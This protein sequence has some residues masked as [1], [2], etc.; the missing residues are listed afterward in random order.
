M[1]L[2]WFHSLCIST[3]L[4]HLRDLLHVHNKNESQMFLGG[5][6]V[7]FG[8][9]LPL[10]PGLKATYDLV[11]ENFLLDFLQ[12]LT[13]FRMLRAWWRWWNFS[14]ELTDN[15]S[16]TSVLSD[17]G[18]MPVSHHKTTGPSRSCQCP[19]IPEPHGLFVM[20]SRLTWGCF[21]LL[22]PCKLCISESFLKRGHSLNFYKGP[23]FIFKK[24]LNPC[25][26]WWQ[27]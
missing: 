27:P 20:G 4:N 5:L 17:S 7:L 3:H 6:L 18:H 1:T 24:H 12:S 25:E 22:S 19:F 13:N 8:I 26:S 23:F 10:A 15:T 11:K 2:L 16:V 21:K 9:S 14:E